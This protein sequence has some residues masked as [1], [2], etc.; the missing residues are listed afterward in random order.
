MGRSI[1][2]AEFLPQINEVQLSWKDT[3][4][5]TVFSS[6]NYDYA[7]IAAPFSK[8]RSWRFPNTCE[9]LERARMMILLK[10]YSIRSHAY[11]RDQGYA[12][13]HCL[14]GKASS[15]FYNGLPLTNLR[16]HS[17]SLPASGSI[18]PTPSLAAVPPRQTSPVLEVSATLATNPTP[19]AQALC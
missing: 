13:H 3:Y 1:Q 9:L 5:D 2:R 18:M 4:T 14:Q 6:A 12:I 8:V 19:P 11:G 15:T 10:Q 16:S 17:N 7:M